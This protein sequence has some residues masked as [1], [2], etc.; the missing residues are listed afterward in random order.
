[1]TRIFDDGGYPPVVFYFH[2]HV[3][4]SSFVNSF[5]VRA[6]AL[7]RV[8][9]GRARRGV[10]APLGSARQRRKRLAVYALCGVVGLLGYG[11][12]PNAVQSRGPDR[13]GRPDRV[14]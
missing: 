1:M 12:A 8:S 9:L 3:Q 11:T 14:V 6:L 10:M 13:V 4:N 7:G 5:H 2:T